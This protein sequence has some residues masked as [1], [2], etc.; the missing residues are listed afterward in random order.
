MNMSRKAGISASKVSASRV[1][2]MS[3]NFMVSLSPM[4]F[5]SFNCY[6]ACRNGLTGE[7]HAGFFRAVSGH[8]LD[9]P[10]HHFHRATLALAHAATA[11]HPDSKAFSESQQTPLLRRPLRLRVRARE[12]DDEAL[13]RIEPRP[14][15]RA[16][17]F[18]EDVERRHA[19]FLEAGGNRI[20]HRFRSAEIKPRAALDQI[21]IDH[22]AGEIALHL[23]VTPG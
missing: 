11:R 5:S 3:N 8:M 21:L 15:R 2:S 7:A 14:G 17:H 19:T 9:L 1:A 16:E 18:P 22:M 12:R 20:H 10:G 6:F 13:R 23:K 4:A